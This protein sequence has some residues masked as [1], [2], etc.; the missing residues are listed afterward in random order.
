MRET[1]PADRTRGLAC[2]AFLLLIAAVA[3]GAPKAKK[4]DIFWQRPDLDSIKVR[5]IAFMPSVAFDH[6]LNK[7]HEAEDAMAITIRGVSYRWLSPTSVMALLKIRPAADSLWK[8]Q[9]NQILKSPVARI[10]SL[11]APTLCQ[12]LRVQAMLTLR[13]DVM[14][15][16]EPEWNQAGKP[17]TTI[18]CKAALVDSAGRLL[19][20]ASGSET[21]EGPY[22]DPGAGVKSVSGSGLSAKPMTGQMG[23]PAYKDVGA[24]LFNRWALSFP[25]PAGTPAP[26]TPAPQN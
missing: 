12:A 8:V 3:G 7:E 19:W 14:E 17:T 20:T 9:R 11:A 16:N 23:A 21:G 13:V 4:V 2:V 25:R 15:V 10:D 1:R 24:T 26:A 22:H 5:S 6:D 18:T